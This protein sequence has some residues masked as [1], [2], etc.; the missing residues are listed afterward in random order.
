MDCEEVL[1]PAPWTQA[2]CSW[3]KLTQTSKACLKCFGSLHPSNTY[4]EP[5]GLTGQVAHPLRPSTAKA[6]Y[7]YWKGKRKKAGR[8]LLRRL[9]APTSASDTNPFAVF[10]RAAVLSACLSLG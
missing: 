3:Q 1:N 4:A 5:G 8:P 7:L 6:A 2:R 9:Q 10:R